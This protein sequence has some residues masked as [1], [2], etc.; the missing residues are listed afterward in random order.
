[1]RRMS[2]RREE[3]RDRV[4]HVGRVRARR[5]DEHAADQRAEYGRHRVGRLQQALRAR[6]L[7]VLDEVGQPRVDS[8]PEEARRE[9]GDC[10]ERHDL[11]GARRER[12]RAEDEEAHDVGGDHHAPAR[13]PVDERPDREADRDRR[14]EVGDQQRR[15]PA[16]GVRPVPDVEVERD[17]RHPAPEAGAEGRVEEQAEAAHP[18]EQVGLPP[19]QTVHDSRRGVGHGLAEVSRV[20]RRSVTAREKCHCGVTLNRPCPPRP[21]PPQPGADVASSSFTRTRSSG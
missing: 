3:E 12:E 1:M 18:V 16:P 13:E 10:R 6:Q 15:D 14:Q 9:T 11:A 2:S 4:H 7:V 17:E 19:E 20:L 8:R 21:R 5:G